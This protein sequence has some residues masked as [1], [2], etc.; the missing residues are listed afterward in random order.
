MS[1]KKAVVKIGADVEEAKKGIDSISSQVDDPPKIAGR[2]TQLLHHGLAAVQ[3]R[4]E[5]GVRPEGEQ[6]GD[7]EG[8]RQFSCIFQK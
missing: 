2:Y 7:T 3:E 1:N 6:R 8:N 5:P 4:E